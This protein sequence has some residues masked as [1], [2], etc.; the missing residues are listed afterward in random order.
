MTA[1]GR[2]QSQPGQRAGREGGGGKGT[3]AAVSE[4]G[5]LVELAVAEDGEIDREDEA[6]RAHALDLLDQALR[7]LARRRRGGGGGGNV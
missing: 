4:L 5:P 1:D 2:W 3:H 6:A 7:D